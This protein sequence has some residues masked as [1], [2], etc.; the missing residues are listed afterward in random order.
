MP[1]NVYFKSH[2]KSVVDDEYGTLEDKLNAMPELYDD[3]D[4]DSFDPAE[5]IDAD[6]LNGVNG[7]EITVM[8]GNVS[9]KET[10]EKQVEVEEPLYIADMIGE[11]TAEQIG[12]AI[13]KINNFSGQ[14]GGVSQDSII[15]TLNEILTNTDDAKIAGALV[16]KEL[17]Q[18]VSDKKTKAASAVTDKGVLTD[19]TDDWDIL[20][21]NILKIAVAIG[22]ATPDNVLEGKTFSNESGEQTGTMPNIGSVSKSLNCSASYTIEK[23]YHDGTGVIKSNSLASQTQATAVAGNVLSSKTVWVNGTKLVGTMIN[24]SGL[25]IE[26]TAVTDEETGN[27]VITLP[28]SGYYDVTTKI[29]VS[30]S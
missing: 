2:I 5:P 18:Y 8:V 9:F 6:M 1:T 29:I 10:V 16:I 15:N 26:V 27:L 22:D 11:Y 12:E 19:A 21:A 7:E 13:E 4:E 25:T 24:K 30:Q 3:E 14:T 23:G 17:F 28:E 20:I